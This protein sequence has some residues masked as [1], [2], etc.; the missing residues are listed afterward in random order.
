MSEESTSFG[1]S[2]NTPS[3]RPSDADL[4]ADLRLHKPQAMEIIYDRYAGIIMAVCLRIVR[5]NATAEQIVETV[6]LDMWE[7]SQCFNGSLV[8]RLVS[9]A[10][11]LAIQRRRATPFVGSAITDAP[12]SGRDDNP[13]ETSDM[14]WQRARTQRALAQV[15]DDARQIVEMICLDAWG[16]VEVAR[17]LK[18]TP[19]SV[20]QRFA[21]GM[22][23]LRDAL[24]TAPPA[25]NPFDPARLPLVNLDRVRV[26]IVD[27]EPDARRALARALQTVGA[28]VTTAAGVAEALELLPEANPD[29]LLSDLAMPDED[30]FDLIRKVRGA[31][32]TVRDLPAVA[33]TAFANVQTRRDAMLAGFQMHVAKPVD[34]HELVE[35]VASL[36]GRTGL[37]A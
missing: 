24:R 31:G 21:T 10:R 8:N 18:L 30:G 9:C 13:T 33:V 15:P 26:L 37:S 7:D 35:V 6:F 12:R 27:D 3:K 25:A 36:T 11:M 4:L 34:P 5:D 1:Q 14:R 19:D 28:L 32:R 23:A 29:L 17:R 22:G 2:Q 20:R 16:V